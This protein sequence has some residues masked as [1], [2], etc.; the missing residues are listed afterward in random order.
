MNKNIAIIVLLIAIILASGC[1]DDEY[2]YDPNTGYT[3]NGHDYTPNKTFT[4]YNWT[5]D[6][7]ELY[8]DSDAINFLEY[9]ELNHVTINNK[10]GTIHKIIII[11]IPDNMENRGFFGTKAETVITYDKHILVG[12][13]K[14]V[15]EYELRFVYVFLNKALAKELYDMENYYNYVCYDFDKIKFDAIDVTNSSF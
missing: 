15:T 13:D 9:D 10:T 3:I 5:D 1:A 4:H 7:R 11:A 12:N 2:V 8:N 6:L 14:I